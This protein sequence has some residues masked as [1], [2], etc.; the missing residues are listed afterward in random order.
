MTPPNWNHVDNELTRRLLNGEELDFGE[1]LG[2]IA[3]AYKCIFD[4]VDNDEIT[5]VIY[6]AR[7]QAYMDA[8]AAFSNADI[9]AMTEAFRRLWSI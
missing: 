6:V 5:D 7:S 8:C 9:P 2:V 4:D 3:F 1:M